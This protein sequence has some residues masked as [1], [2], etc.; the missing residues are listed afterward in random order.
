MQG[1]STRRLLSSGTCWSRHSQQEGCGSQVDESSGWLTSCSDT[2][3]RGF[4]MK[5]GLKVGLH[6]KRQR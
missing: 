2:C 3:D 1:R 4:G 6:F 5:L